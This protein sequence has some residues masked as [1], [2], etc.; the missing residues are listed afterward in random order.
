MM[1][2]AVAAQRVTL[3][4]PVDR[5]PLGHSGL[6][7]SPLCLG[8]TASPDTVI[9]AY[10]C[11]VNF[12]FVT[13]DLHWQLDEGL[14]KCVGKLFAGRRARRDEVVVGGVSYLDKPLFGALQFHE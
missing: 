8:L 5:I 1:A 4:K 13:G 14:R 2:T 7:V 12:F 6:R 11:G 10:E 9:A 3:P